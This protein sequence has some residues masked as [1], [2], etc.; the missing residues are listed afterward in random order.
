VGERL[1]LDLRFVTSSGTQVRL[2]QLVGAG[3]PALLVLAYNRCAMLCSLVLRG[4]SD[5]VR[6]SRLSPGEHYAVV[7]IGI[8]PRESAHEAA[9][10]QASALERAGRPGERERWPFLVGEHGSVPLL[11]RALGF[12]Y[13]W[14]PRTQQYA[15]PAVV[16][17]IDAEGR[18]SRYF[19][20]LSLDAAEVEGA[21]GGLPQ[22]RSTAH[23]AVTAILD[24]FRF[25]A[26]SR[27]YGA[28]IQTGSRAG[29][30]LVLVA[31]AGLVGVLFAR[32]RRH[33]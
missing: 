8:N 18:I 13:T 15:H 26:A 10:T 4:V 7:T 16:F 25:D 9:R 2:G 28:A 5:F 19:Y 21:L 14:D 17:V 6:V 22:T 20:G 29:A 27:R 31:V 30:L 23:S 1:P 3:K 12:E 33:S 32:S 24:C 11:A